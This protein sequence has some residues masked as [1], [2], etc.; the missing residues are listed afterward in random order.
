MSVD[1]V[2]LCV[3]SQVGLVSVDRVVLRVCVVSGR[4]GECGLCCVVLCV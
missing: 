4:A 2:V 1:R 3:W